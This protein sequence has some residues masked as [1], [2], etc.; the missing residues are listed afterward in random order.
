MKKNALV[1]MAALSVILMATTVQAIPTSVVGLGDTT[2]ENVQIG[3][4]NNPKLENL[5]YWFAENGVTNKDGSAIDPLTDQSQAELFFT[6]ETREYEIEFLGIGHAG[7]HSPFGVFVYNG[8][9]YEDYD[10]DNMTYYDPLFVQ[11]EVEEN[12][13]YNF[14]IEAGSYFGFYLDSNG[15]GT[16]LTTMVDANPKARSKRVHN[17]DQYTSG[18]DHAIFFETNKGYTMAFEDIVGGGDVDYE[19]L[20]VNFNP[21]DGSGFNPTPEPGTML[22]LGLGLFGA[23][24]VRKRKK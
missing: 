2:I 19:D 18:L 23:V 12:T 17:K 14:M 20:V 13:T 1:F 3:Y 5:E 16:K 21:T 4:T 9:P 7:Y 6:D 22:L 8:N 11:N 10:A 15:R 24:V